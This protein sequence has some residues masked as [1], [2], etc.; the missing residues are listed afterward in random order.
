MEANDFHLYCRTLTD[1]QLENV[2]AKEYEAAQ[3]FGGSRE[4]DYEGAVREAER[5][6]WTVH[7]GQ[8]M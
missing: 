8:R 2:L 6:G 4:Q 1:A 5:R 3:A 7:N